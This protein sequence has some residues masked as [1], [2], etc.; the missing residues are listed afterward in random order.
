MDLYTR[1]R[2]ARTLSGLSARDLARLAEV[3]PSTVTR[4]ENREIGD[5]SYRVVQRILDAVDLGPDLKPL[6]RPSALAAA[7]ILLGDEVERPADFDFWVDRWRKLR[8]VGAD[9][10]PTNVRDLAWRAARSASL[11]HRPGAVFVRRALD[12]AD[13]ARLFDDADLEWANTGDSA[14]NRISLFADQTWP[15]FYVSDVRT[16]LDSLSAA[17]FLPNEDGPAMTLIPFDGTS[18]AGRWRDTDQTGLV[19][20]APWQ[21]VLDCFAGMQRMPDQAERILDLW[22]AAA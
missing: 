1:I 11:A 19:Y 2:I 20:A 21:V 18:E 17:P 12:L 10:Q 5:V 15:V 3:A 7:R 22:G 9:G 6:S 14:A 4:I 8:V 16:A 13:V